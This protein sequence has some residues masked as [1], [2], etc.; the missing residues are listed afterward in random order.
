MSPANQLIEEAL[1][2]LMRMVMR[3]RR[4]FPN[5][6]LKMNIVLHIPGPISQPDYEG[7]HATRLDRRNQHLLVVAAVPSTLRP[8]EVSSYFAGLL[9]EARREAISYIGKRKVPIATEKV[10]A[11]IDHLLNEIESASR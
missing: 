1:A 2:G 11:L 6:G 3:E 10:S 7:V 5:E 4:L 9:V 8:D